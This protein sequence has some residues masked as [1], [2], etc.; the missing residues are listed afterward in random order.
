MSSFE[1][2]ARYQPLHQDLARFRPSLLSKDGFAKDMRQ[3]MPGSGLSSKGSMCPN[4][5][6]LGLKVV[7]I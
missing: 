7:P 3:M 5:I 4:S 6:Y 2:W 1:P